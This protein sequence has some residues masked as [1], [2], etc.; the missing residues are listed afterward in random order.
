MLIN[1]EDLNRKNS[2]KLIVDKKLSNDEK[3]ELN[4]N[5]IKNDNSIKDIN[6]EISEKENNIEKITL[7]L[8]NLNNQMED[9][10]KEI[11]EKFQIVLVYSNKIK[12]KKVKKD[13]ILFCFS[14]LYPA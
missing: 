12:D 5:I 4:E 11:E 14:K 3:K 2:E 1:L 8:S 13:R 10:T 9:L 7:K 6:N